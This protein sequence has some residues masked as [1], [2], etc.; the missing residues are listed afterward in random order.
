MTLGRAL[1]AVV[2]GIEAVVVEVEVDLADGV[3]GTAVVGLADRGVAE[4]K[5][6]VRAALV[7]SGQ[8]WPAKRVTIGLSPA[9]LPKVGVVPDLAIAAA[10]L[11]ADGVVPA[12]AVDEVLVLGELGLDG[13]VR[14]VRGVLPALIAA[15][16]AGLKRAVI[17]TSAMH[18]ACWSPAMEV[19][20]ITSVRHL[21][22]VLTGA[23][24]RPSH[25]SVSAAAVPSTQASDAPMVHKDL[26][27]VYG[28]QQARR[29]L[30]VAAVGGHHL[31]LH[32]PPGGGKTMLA[33]RLPGI[34]PSLPAEHQREV[35]AIASVG[36]MATHR[37]GPGA[38][39]WRPFEAPH[40]SASLAAVVGGGSGRIAPGAV[41]RAHRGVLFLDEAP[42]FS[43]NVLDALREPLES[44]EVAVSRSGITA[45]LP[46]AFQLVM[47][48]NPCPCGGGDDGKSCRCTPTQRRRYAQRLSGPLLDRLDLIVRTDGGSYSTLWASEDPPESSAQV[49]ARVAEAVER[50]QH[51]L[52]PLSIATNATIPG[53]ALRSGGALA[54]TRSQVG[55]LWQQSR[56]IGDSAR[57]TDKTLRVAWTIADL[58]GHA[59]LTDECVAEAVSLRDLALLGAP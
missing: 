27:E 13:S 12:A 16:R 2:V 17:P 55:H 43:R 53:R 9:W 59:T 44:G 42:E 25:E 48:A 10:M 50:M 14:D 19:M 51:R 37:F 7:N 40:H 39:T 6:R 5:D 18:E 32:G 52:A 28:Q 45:R 56:Q 54:P 58:S 11:V 30:E 31:L 23:Q 36:E 8:R 35:A 3:V 29:A 21:I 38:M 49:A 46:A 47:A 24:D 41:T 33:E 1:G 57:A 15:E 22:A 20:G 26:A 4:A 34:L